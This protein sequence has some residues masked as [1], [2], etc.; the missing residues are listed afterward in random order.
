MIQ[1]IDELL[2]EL[3]KNSTLEE[4]KVIDKML[5]MWRIRLKCA[6]ALEEARGER[7]DK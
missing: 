7:D 5:R 6:D 4:R 1:Q 2:T 3:V